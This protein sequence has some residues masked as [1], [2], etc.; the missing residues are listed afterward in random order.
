MAA[1]EASPRFAGTALTAFLLAT[2]ATIPAA[3]AELKVTV[4]MKP[5]HALVAGVMEGIGEPKLLVT[6]SASPH[7]FSMKPSDAKALNSSAVFFR[8]SERV[9][10]FTTKVVKSLPKEV[11]TVTLAETPG[12]EL[13]EVRT[14]ETFER[15]D[16]GHDDHDDHGHKGHKGHEHQKEA[17]GHSDHGHDNDHAAHPD[18]AEDHAKAHDGHVWLDPDNAKLMVA[19]IVRVLSE[20]SP[21]NAETFKTNGERVTA[22]ITALA[23]EIAKDLEPIKGKPFVVFHDAYQYFEHHFG[24]TAIGSITMSPEVQPS[25]KRLTEI[26]KKLKTLEASCVFAEPQFKPK[27]VATVTEGTSARAGTLDPEGAL[28]EP[29]KGAYTALLKNLASG[30]KSCLSQ[31][32]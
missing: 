14:G 23:A 29:G 32:S 11:R 2:T 9:E 30:L 25:A 16:H 21:E 20:V 31:G 22:E 13:L 18:H 10:P 17:K 4:T 3:A 1:S 5:I 8:V 15:H 28:V 24:L 7:T 26:R 6:G 19:E 27:L 12:L